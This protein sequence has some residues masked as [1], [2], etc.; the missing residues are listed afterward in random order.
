MKT[1]P[2]YAATAIIARSVGKV[3]WRK[4]SNNEISSSPLEGIAIIIRL[5]VFP[6]YYAAL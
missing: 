4:Y 1:K 5:M 3:S 6:F 2:E